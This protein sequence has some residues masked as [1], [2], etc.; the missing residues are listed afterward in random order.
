MVGFSALL[1]FSLCF[2]FLFFLVV[3]AAGVMPGGNH[4]PVT[5]LSSSLSISILCLEYNVVYY[6]IYKLCYL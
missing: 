6:F 5:N 3:G 1:L 4:S 2:L